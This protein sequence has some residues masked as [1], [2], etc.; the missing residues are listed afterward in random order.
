M[1]LPLILWAMIVPKP[2]IVPGEVAAQKLPAPHLHSV[3]GNCWA[4]G[5]L[6]SL[7]HISEVHL[8]GVGVRP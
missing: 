1:V 6:V 7:T 8:H 5:T 2:L 3:P 4:V